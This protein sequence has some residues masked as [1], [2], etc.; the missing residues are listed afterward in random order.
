MVFVETV[1]FSRR[2]ATIL[3]DDEYSSLQDM[4]VVRPDAG[5]VIQGS[6][7]IRK[8]RWGTSGRG[9]SGG[10]R[11]IYYWKA[12]HDKIL[13]LAVYAKGEKQDLTGDE[14]KTLRRVVEGDAE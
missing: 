9:K 7:G 6:G 10:A 5:A 12:T 1:A 14:I 2:I 13:M 4:L 3:N 11:I 8:L